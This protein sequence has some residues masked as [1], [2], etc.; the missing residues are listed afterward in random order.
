LAGEVRCQVRHDIDRIGRHHEHRLGSVLENAGHDLAEYL[1]VA[2]QQLQPRFAGLLVHSGRDH[3]DAAARQ[4]GIVS[5]AHGQGPGKGDCMD[6]VLSFGLGALPVE[7]DQH[8][9]ATHAAHDHG[10]GGGATH[11]AGPD[12][13]NSHTPSSV[14]KV[15]WPDC[16][17]RDRGGQPRSL[18]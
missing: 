17:P 16:T 10:K 1:G 7:V 18:S 13:A 15:V 2:L 9:L 5:G 12:D 8:D 4:V 14:S 3:D 6:E 11:Q